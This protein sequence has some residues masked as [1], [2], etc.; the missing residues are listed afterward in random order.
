MEYPSK[1]YG[2]LVGGLIVYPPPFVMFD[3]FFISTSHRVLTG[4]AR[5]R[6]SGIDLI[7]IAL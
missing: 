2:D 4:L 7:S 3:L 6:L 5:S 1:G